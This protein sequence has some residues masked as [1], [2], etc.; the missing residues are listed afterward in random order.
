ME[1]IKA[2]NNLLLFFNYLLIKNK[3]KFNKIKN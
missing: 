2:K 1:K 3:N